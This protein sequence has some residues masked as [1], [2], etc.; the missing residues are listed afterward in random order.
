MDPPWK[1]LNM[2]FL[3]RHD[4]YCACIANDYKQLVLYF[5]LKKRSDSFNKTRGLH[6]HLCKALFQLIIP[7]ANFP[8]MPLAT[9]YAAYTYIS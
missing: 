4:I 8:C 3:A 1:Y 6:E 7:C 2:I 9:V 5:V